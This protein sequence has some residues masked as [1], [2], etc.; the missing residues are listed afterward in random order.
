[1]GKSSS[2]QKFCKIEDSRNWGSIVLSHVNCAA[3]NQLFLLLLMLLM[4]VPPPV[5]IPLGCFNGVCEYG[6]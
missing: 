2:N 5:G 3:F 1:M 6:F 4:Y